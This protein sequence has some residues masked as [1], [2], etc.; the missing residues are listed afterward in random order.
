MAALDGILDQLERDLD[1]HPVNSNVFFVRFRD[2]FL[3]P[4]DLQT[5]LRQYQY[6]CKHFVKLLEGLLF[7]TPVDLLDMRIGLVKTLHSELGG[8]DARRAHIVLLNRFAQAIGLDE[9]AL[10]RTVPL[11]STSAYLAVL[12]RLF[13]EADYLTALGAE[14]AVEKTA[15]AEFQSLYPGLVK[16]GRFPDDTLEFFK[17]HLNEEQCHA[18]WLKQAVRTTART[19]A[20]LETVAAGARQTADAWHAFWLGLHDVVFARPRAITA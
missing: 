12:H 16:Y 2:E 1:S 8:S 15:V 5:F 14:F 19:Q 9:A 13:I 17:L 10:A 20:D 3:H 11:P 4:D 7:R 6:F 18:D